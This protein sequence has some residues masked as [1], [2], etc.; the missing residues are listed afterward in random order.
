MLSDLSWL[1]PP[2]PDFRDR[3]K[4]ISD[5]S[6]GQRAAEPELMR[7][8]SFRLNEPQLSQVARAASGA[9]S[10]VAG[11]SRIRLGLSGDGTLS[12]L[13][14][15]LA[16]TGIR[17][18]LL[19][20]VVEGGFNSA[21]QDASDP[22]SVLRSAELD[23]L[24][25][26]TDRR[27]SGLSA[28]AADEEEARRRVSAAIS[29][30]KMVVN[31]HRPNVRG[32][33]LVQ[34]MPGPVEALF[35]S[36][37]AVEGTSA[38]SMV[39]RFNLE[40]VDW[41]R[42]G[43][44][45]LVDIARLSAN[46]GLER[47][48]DPR[49]WFASKLSFSP[50]MLPIYADVVTRTIAAAAGR[51]KKALVLDLDNTLWGGVIGD[52]GLAGLRLGHGNATGEAHLAL[53]G[54]ALELRSRGVI[55]A[56]CSKNEDDVARSAFR[57]HPEMLLREE[58]IA[59]FTA[60]WTDKA[61]NLRTI[62]SQLNIGLD[63]LVFLDD[64]PAEREQVRRELP[65]VSVPEICTD[66]STYA[67]VLASAGYFESVAF[68]SEDRVRADQYQ[69][70]VRRQASLADAA[71]LDAYLCSLDMRLIIRPFDQLARPRI[72]QLINKSN[73]FNL[74]TRRYSE[75]EVAAMEQDPSKYAISL[76]LTD[77][78]GDNGL[79]SVIIVECSGKVWTIDSW[80][81]SCRVLGRR[82]EQAAL[83]HLIKAARAC[84]AQ[85][86]VGTYIPTGR[87]RIVAKHY[88]ALGFE[89]F[90]TSDT[91]QQWRLM[92]ADA[93]PTSDLPMIV[94]DDA[95]LQQAAA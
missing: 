67:R 73:Q 68:T 76:R 13:A 88:E 81:M 20:D 18:G 22:D 59:V 38:S 56:V 61:T 80:L 24:L 15:P 75:A 27:H 77:A 66:P 87:N 10:A 7:L 35:G 51:S 74:T 21:V 45:V 26:T 58:H 70:N 52:D 5:G 72:T 6:D 16:G 92:L 78:F 69:V 14:N 91:K 83:A 49:H 9:T 65:M 47:W 19:L 31:G 36:L 11:L 93:R 95:H 55:L 90:A 64:N 34:T 82:V 25:L 40:L 57:E 79:I 42:S 32:S 37:D 4:R 17:H 62:A 41:A 46:V 3:L 43:E 39:Q 89:P 71:D 30:L 44:V 86:L 85:E 2:P 8:A 54:L 50:D 84:G 48:D 94:D 53:Q 1:K 12:L 28:A 29:R 63:A 23:M 60:N 33:I